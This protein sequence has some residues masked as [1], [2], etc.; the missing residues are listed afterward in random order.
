MRASFSVHIKLV[1]THSTG[2][3]HFFVLPGRIDSFLMFYHP[4]PSSI[5]KVMAL[6]DFAGSSP[7]IS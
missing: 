7:Q 4:E 3:I 6:L 2:V 5:S 1:K